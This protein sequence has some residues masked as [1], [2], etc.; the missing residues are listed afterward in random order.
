MQPNDNNCDENGIA[1]ETVQFYRDVLE[2]LNAAKLPYLV[3]GGFAFNHYTGL[4]RT[5]KDFDIFIQRGDYE[6]ISRLLTNAGLATELTYPHWLGKI[7]RQNDVVDLVF[8]SGNGVAEVDR[9]W[10]DHSVSAKICDIQTQLCPVEETIWSKSFVMERERFDGADVAHLI[11]ATGSTMDWH[12]LLARFAQHWRL[13]LSHLVL[14]GFIYPAQK[15][16]IP[17]WVLAELLYLLTQEIQS[18]SPKN[19]ICAGTLLSREQYLTDIKKLGYQDA[20]VMP[21]GKMTLQDTINWTC[22]IKDKECG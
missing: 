12:R 8:S 11:L 9:V 1:I 22:A 7:R 14:F 17:A 21:L 15:N 19:N 13:L 18:I 4:N 16:Q 2:K 10:F 3:G 20:R 5:T 6:K